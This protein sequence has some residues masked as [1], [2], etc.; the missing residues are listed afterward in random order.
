MKELEQLEPYEL[1]KHLDSFLHTEE[2]LEIE[3][4]F[5]GKTQYGQ[6]KNKVQVKAG[7]GKGRW[8]SHKILKLLVIL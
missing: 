2:K 7:E 8:Y 6:S 1:S 5:I 4:K 3:S